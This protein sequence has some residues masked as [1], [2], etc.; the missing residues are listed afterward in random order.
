M[1]AN[2]FVLAAASAATPAIGIVHAQQPA[3]APTTND[4]IFTGN[5]R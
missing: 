1:R 2:G 3:G 5:A 4:G